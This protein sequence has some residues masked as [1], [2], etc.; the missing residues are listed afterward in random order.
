MFG[1]FVPAENGRSNQT[2][3]KLEQRQVQFEPQAR[4]VGQTRRV[5][6][7][8]EQGH[9][10]SRNRRRHQRFERSVI[11]FFLF[12][13]L[14]VLIV[15]Y[16]LRWAYAMARREWR[17]DFFPFFFVRF[18]EALVLFYTKTGPVLN[19]YFGGV[20]TNNLPTKYWT[21]IF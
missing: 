17:A 16:R 4:A 1:D 14:D 13:F 6:R 11:V 20:V 19:I 15:V 10:N 9:L 7:Q 12:F 5:Q 21:T 3:A 8:C 2:R 18:H